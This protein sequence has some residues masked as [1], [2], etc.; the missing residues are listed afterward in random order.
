M[1]IAQ[2][3][4]QLGVT[5]LLLSMILILG[6]CK[7]KDDP[8]PQTQT[9]KIS[10]SS[11]VPGSWVITD[12]DSGGVDIYTQKYRNQVF[13]FTSDNKY[14]SNSFEKGTWSLLD[15]D[16][17]FSI[18]SMSDTSFLSNDWNINRIDSNVIVLEG[19]NWNLRF[20]K[21]DKVSY[22]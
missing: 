12:L 2:K 1:K 8:A 5:T 11:Y 6:N 16:S 20:T 22:E 9:P 7:K 17:V 15:T 21:S 3:T 19:S 4:K 10:L 18:V 13:K 14:T